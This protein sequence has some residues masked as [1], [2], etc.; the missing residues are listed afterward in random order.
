MI[1]LAAGLLLGQ[2]AYQGYQA[3]QN[4]QEAER[5]AR[6]GPQ[7]PTPQAFKEMQA[8]Q[9]NQANN[10]QIAGYGEALE[11]LNEQQSTTLGEARR[12]GISSSNLM[13]VLTRL[14]QQQ[15]AEKR[16]LA[17]AGAAEKERR[18]NE[19][20][21]TLGMRSQYQE[22][23]RQENARAIGAL[24]GASQQNVFNALTTGIGAAS[25]G[26]QA[27]EAAKDAQA[28]K[29]AQIEGVKFTTADIPTTPDPIEMGDM[30]GPAPALTPTPQ[31]AG[32]ENVDPALMSQS[33]LNPYVYQP[34]GTNTY[35]PQMFADYYARK[36][37][38][39]G[40]TF[41]Q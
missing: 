11:N 19:L 6:L 24:R 29:D 16:K 8:N 1:P 10:A 28:K 14:N 33:V 17:M 20:N 40:D 7:D 12:A 9:A 37:K 2:A 39:Q 22:Q 4:Q 32:M 5:L 30:G 13:N 3:Y 35:T 25:Y 18:Q 31:M 27:A 36:R 41:N 21:R 15:S 34:Q 26:M 38:Y 23:G